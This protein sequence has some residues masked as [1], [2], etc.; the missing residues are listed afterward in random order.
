MEGNAI[1]ILAVVVVLGIVLLCAYVLVNSFTPE[2]IMALA[3][4]V[5]VV[6]IVAIGLLAIAINSRD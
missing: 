2:L 1:G 5:A 4:I 6:T 3:C